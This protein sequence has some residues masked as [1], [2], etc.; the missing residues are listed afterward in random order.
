MRTR[1][2]FILFVSLTSSAVAEAVTVSIDGPKIRLADLVGPKLGGLREVGPAPSPGSRRRIYRREVAHLLAGKRVGRLPGHWDVVTR[3]QELSCG[4]LARLVA[5]AVEPSLRKGLSVT[6]VS[7]ARPLTLPAGTV[8]ASARLGGGTRWAGRLPAT[9]RIT[10]GRW[11]AR[12][13]VLQCQVDG[14]VSTVVATKSLRSGKVPKPGSV[15]VVTRRA[16]RLPWDALTGLDDLVGMKLNGHL[17]AGR[18]IRRGNLSPVPIMKR[19]ASITLAVLGKGVRLTVRAIARQDGRRGDT[20][21][22]L[23]KATNRMLRARIVG[24]RRVVVDL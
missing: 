16:S 4:Q 19:G 24:P 10:V 3:K 17:R 9:V 13:M 23:C 6:A 7:C 14:L 22:V 20:I 1:L 21:L 15:Q 5:R 2:A 8:T 11:A 18:V 12:I